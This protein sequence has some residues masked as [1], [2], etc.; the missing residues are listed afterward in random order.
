MATSNESMSPFI[1]DDTNAFCIN[2][3]TKPERWE[4]MQRRFQHFDMKVQRWPAATADDIVDNFPH[5]LNGGQKGCAQS[6]IHI[7]RHMLEKELPYALI[8]EDDACFDQRWKEKLA[9]FCASNV[10]AEWDAV[11]LNASE[12]IDERDVWSCTRDREQYLTAGYV[13]SNKGARVLLRDFEHCFYSSDWMTS[14]IQLHGHSYCYFPWL[15]IQEGADSNIG[16]NVEADHAK[17]L[18]CLNEID[19]SMDNYI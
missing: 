16:S 7:W 4:K 3:D 13:L 18:R 1:F 6:H 10:D 8:L 17:V 15:I 12:P 5:Y 11:F 9:L 2:L 14:R 19:Y